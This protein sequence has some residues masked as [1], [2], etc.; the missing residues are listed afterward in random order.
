[1]M[2]SSIDFTNPSEMNVYISYTCVAILLIL[3]VYVAFFTSGANGLS[4]NV[5]LIS[6]GIAAFAFL[7]V[8]YSVAS[9]LLLL[10]VVILVKKHMKKTNVLPKLSLPMPKPVE[11]PMVK[12]MVKLPSIVTSEEEPEKPVNVE[13]LDKMVYEPIQ[14]NVVD[15]G[16]MRTE[17][18][19]FNQQL[20]PQGLSD[21][22]GYD[23]NVQDSL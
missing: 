15:P 17:V 23:M 20:G 10:I 6:L 19:T 9:M 16:N 7:F 3:V 21:P 18:R 8:D 13:N 1:M 2:E 4:S 12:S 14:S 22:Q 5:S 11:K